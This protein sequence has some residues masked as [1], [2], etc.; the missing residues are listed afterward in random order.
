MPT[1]I[2]KSDE[3]SAYV[4]KAARVATAL[5]EGALVILPTETVYGIA[6]NAASAE[7][8]RRLRRVKGRSDAQPFTIHLGRRADAGLFVQS[9]P[10]LARR[11][12]RKAWP[13]PLTIIC[14]EPTPERTRVAASVPAGQLGELFHEGT[15]GLRCPDHPAA[16]AILS[17]AGVPVVA[18]SANRA[19][20]PP[21]LELGAALE[22]LGGEVE[23]AIDAGRT[24]LSEASTIVEV[25]GRLY[26]LRRSGVLDERT[27][28]RMARS[29]ILFVCTGNSCR[30]PLAAYLFRQ[31]LAEQLGVEVRELEREGIV[32]MSA[33]THAYSGGAAS[34]GTLEEL[35]RR[36]IDAT[37]HRSRPVTIE[38]LKRAERVFCMSPEH[39]ESVLDVLP[40][41]VRV[42]LL[43][44]EGRPVPDPIGGT[45]EDYRRTADQIEKAVSA[46]VE[47]FVDEDRNW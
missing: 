9:P 20:R 43:D 29:E 38:L 6:A 7:A 14:E 11:L 45:A 16:A 8:M 30:S 37:A 36:G 33:G 35:R 22:E 44:P 39:R 26:S 19:G 3:I 1:E 12:S 31:K 10:R 28:A 24:R 15:V 13:G 21:P 42:D 4:D 47:E 5:R 27:I 25:R 23:I 2:I 17:G 46:R 41:T 34:S 32:V 18:S 40:G